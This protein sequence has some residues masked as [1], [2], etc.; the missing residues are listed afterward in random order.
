MLALL[1]FAIA[2][3]SCVLGPIDIEGHPCPC[4]SGYFCGSDRFCHL[5]GT[6]ADGGEIPDGPAEAGAFILTV[7]RQG[8]RSGTVTSGPAGIDCGL[9]C[10]SRF[11]AGTP[12]TLTATPDPGAGRAH[13]R[14]RHSASS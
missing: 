4:T 6:G 11:V 10:A 12:V 7:D 13:A 1:G 3:A 5:Q 14:A 9:S 2:G 8:C